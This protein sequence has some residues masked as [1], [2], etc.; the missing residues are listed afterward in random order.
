MHACARAAHE[1]RVSIGPP[2]FAPGS[3]LAPPHGPRTQARRTYTQE[4]VTLWYRAPELLLGKPEYSASVDLWSTGCI[5]AEIASR[6]PLFP[7]D[8]EI[9]Q[10][11]KIF[12]L[13]GTPTEEIWSGVTALPDYQPHFPR[14]RPSDFSTHFPQMHS[15]TIDLLSQLVTYQ[16]RDRLR[17]TEAIQHAFFDDMRGSP[18]LYTPLDSYLSSTPPSTSASTTTLS[19]VSSIR[20]SRRSAATTPPKKMPMQSSSA[21]RSR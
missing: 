15:T 9:D 10:L 19:S 1:R 18:R 16:P 8:S 20:L 5:L 7:G 12:Q 11:F 2:S 6:R 4:V 3:P 14:W 21:V 13:L 17:A